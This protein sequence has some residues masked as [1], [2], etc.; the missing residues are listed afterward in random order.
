MREKVGFVPLILAKPHLLQIE[1][2]SVIVAKCD[3]L[4]KQ[5]ASVITTI[6]AAQMKTDTLF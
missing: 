6:A 3:W 4:S 2:T 1:N 5:A